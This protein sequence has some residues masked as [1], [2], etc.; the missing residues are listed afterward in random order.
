M[1]RQ[2]IKTAAQLAAEVALALLVVGLLVATWMP[3]IWSAGDD[4]DRGRREP[5]PAAVGGSATGGEGASRP[6]VA[7]RRVSSAP[8]PAAAGRR[9]TARR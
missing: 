1:K 2:T 8:S 4:A 9:A 3:A 5:R 7:G 6:G